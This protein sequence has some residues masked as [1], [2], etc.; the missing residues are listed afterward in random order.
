LPAV[1][2]VG[3]PVDLALSAL[4]CLVCGCLGRQLPGLLGLGNA[5]Q[6]LAREF[7]LELPQSAVIEE[8]LV[9][10]NVDLA[11]AFVSEPVKFC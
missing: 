1:L 3:H 4:A 11:A 2:P 6:P 10:Q 5:R 7:Q 8:F 9:G